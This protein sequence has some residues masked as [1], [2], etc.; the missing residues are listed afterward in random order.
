MRQDI[1]R[2][3]VLFLPAPQLAGWQ[4]SLRQAPALGTA[5]STMPSCHVRTSNGT[6]GN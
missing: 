1:G 2:I 4:R 5:R 6:R 3:L